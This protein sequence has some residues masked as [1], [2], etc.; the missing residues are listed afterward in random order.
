M[1]EKGI[2]PFEHLAAENLL[3]TLDAVRTHAAM[4][5]RLFGAVSGYLKDALNAL[6]QVATA[7]NITTE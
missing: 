4:Q 3:I 5:E 1:S 2:N 6:E 7:R